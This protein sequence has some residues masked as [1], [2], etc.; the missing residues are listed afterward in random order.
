MATWWSTFL[1]S[2]QPKIIGPIVIEQSIL[3]TIK[4]VSLLESLVRR[5][6]A[7]RPDINHDECGSFH[8]NDLPNRVAPNLTFLTPQTTFVGIVSSIIG[9]PTP[10]NKMDRNNEIIQLYPNTIEN[11]LLHLEYKKFVHCKD[12]NSY[13]SLASKSKVNIS[14][15]WC[16]NK[17]TQRILF[18]WW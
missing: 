9:P 12:I 4:V 2:N 14:D 17:T 8:A 13:K 7:A 1:C 10:T 11:W 15:F 3:T 6:W 5:Y 18:I 16:L